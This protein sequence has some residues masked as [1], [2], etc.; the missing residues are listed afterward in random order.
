MRR[1]SIP[2]VLLAAVSL[3]SSQAQKSQDYNLSVNVELVQ[4]PVSV[5]DK[6]GF[7]VQGLKQE[8]FAVYEDKV[9]Q[10]ISLFKQE[11]VPLSIALVVDASGSMTDKVRTLFTAADTFVRESNPEDETSVVSF[12]DEV[13]LDQDFTQNMHDLNRALSEITPNGNTALYDAV[14]LAAKHLKENG[15]HEKKVLLI[16][17]DGED[18]H[19]KYQLKEVL[20]TIRASKIIVYSIGLLSSDLGYSNSYAF[21]GD[22][23]KALKQLAEIPGGAA[24]F[25]KGRHEVEQVCKRIA[26]DLRNQYTIGYKPRNDNLDGSWRK[27]VVKVNPPQ[28]IRKV[29]IRTKQGYYAPVAR[30]SQRA[31]A[32]PTFK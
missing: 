6:N 30:D 31:S 8:H 22:G 7:P 21:A 24:F 11:D 1:L 28:T 20:E 26:R 10:D 29:T 19:S 12:G 25:P 2:I 4:L 27:T 13:S 16:I 9:L 14:F 5:L 32:Q 17:S 23:K 18:N 3:A 15:Y